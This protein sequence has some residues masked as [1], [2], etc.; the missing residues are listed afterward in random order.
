MTMIV[1]P[2]ENNLAYNCLIFFITVWSGLNFF[3]I[4]LLKYVLY[5]YYKLDSFD[6]CLVFCC[7]IMP[8]RLVQRY[9][10]CRIEQRLV[11]VLKKAPPIHLDFSLLF[12]LSVF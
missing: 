11:F 9:T 10:K 1:I 7:P 3:F 6:V 2:S 12:Y 8:D 5:E 4:D